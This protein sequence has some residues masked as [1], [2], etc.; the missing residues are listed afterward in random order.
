MAPDQKQVGY[1]DDVIP[2]DEDGIILSGTLSPEAVQACLDAGVQSWI[3]LNEP[4]NENSPIAAVEAAGVAFK[5]VHLSPRTPVTEADS[6]RLISAIGDLP[7]P[8]L[9]QCNSAVR[10]GVAFIFYKASIENLDAV[11][12]LEKAKEMNLK[13]MLPK[14]EKLRL[15]VTNILKG[16]GPD[17]STA[18]SAQ[19]KSGSLKQRATTAADHDVERAS[20]RPR[21][22]EES[23]A[24]TQE[25]VE[26]GE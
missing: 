16:A 8:T 19:D 26:C 3:N 23:N 7:R 9:I 5:C 18:A 20:K 13:F 4:D 10:A 2:Y 6:K 21:G 11:S 22:K 24:A 15:G 14:W 17:G 12:A 1:P 25:V